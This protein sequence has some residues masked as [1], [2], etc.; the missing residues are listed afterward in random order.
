MN[1]I[2]GF[3]KLIRWVNLL[4]IALSMYLFQFCIIRTFLDAANIEPSLNW[5]YFSLLVLS[6]VFIAAAG[7]IANAYFDYEQDAEFRPGKTIVGR[8]ISLD[9]AFGLQMGLNI[10]G[11]LIA[12]FLAYHFEK[13]KL[14][15]VFLSAAALLWLY[16]QVLKKYFLVGN[17]VVAGLSA[18]VF[19]LPVLF[20]SSLYN[21]FASDNLELA[22][23][24]ILNQ[25]KWYCLFA[26]VVS[27]MREIVKDAE[28]KEADAAYDMKTLPV[29]LPTAAVNAIIALMMIGTMVVIGYIEMYYWQRGLK[30]H[31]WYTLF[32]LTFPLLTD[33]FLILTARKKTDYQN[34]SILLKLLMF[35]GIAS[36]PV[37]YLFITKWR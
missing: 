36:M 24:I 37:F 20:E 26:F 21:V 30:K 32:F 1:R 28:D 33:L 4:I 34:L 10:V 2:I 16:S 31:F 25:L 7:N 6:T 29:V 18:L 27:L 9:T 22:K 3:L 5:F 13:I 11:V 23:N 15:Y 17:L 12:F 19:V 8:Y 35:F 14:G